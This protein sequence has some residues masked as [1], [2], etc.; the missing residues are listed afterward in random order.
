[1]VARTAAFVRSS[2]PQSE[3]VLRVRQ[4][5]APAFSFLQPAHPLHAFFRYMVDVDPEARAAEAKRTL[6]LL[7]AYGEAEGDTEAGDQ[8]GAEAAKRARDTAD[9]A[10]AAP[11]EAVPAPAD[12]PA[13]EPV[14]AE[15]TAAATPPVPPPPPAPAAMPAPALAPHEASAETVAV[16]D[17]L[18]A[19]VLKSGPEFEATLRRRQGAS[20]A[21][22]FLQPWSPLNA[23]Y[24]R[25]LAAAR[26]AAEA[27]AAAAAAAAAPP[28]KPRRPR[29]DIAAPSASTQAVPSAALP[30]PAAEHVA[31][32]VED[33]ISPEDAAA[34]AAAAAEEERRLERLRR[35]REFS[36]KRAADAR[37]AAVS[38]HASRASAHRN[39]FSVDD[40]DDLLLPDC[41]APPPAPLP[42]PPALLR[43]AEPRAGGAGASLADAHAAA[44]TAAARAAR[45]APAPP[46]AFPPHS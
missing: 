22:A 8:E 25:K 3:I 38:A 32:S 13:P 6:A 12:A 37:T 29:W 4:A 43:R 5:D 44:L 28:P 15:E 18:V 14:P 30:Q 20:P 27:E 31:A 16:M 1:M 7:S 41:D 21:F 39:V 42:P 17:K 2:G 9:A 11:A 23:L 34:A 40:D 19:F 35:V 45:V 10:A 26:A 36:A 24:V 46:R 33:E